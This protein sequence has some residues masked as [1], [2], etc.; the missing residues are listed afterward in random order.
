MPFLNTFEN[1]DYL[2]HGL[3]LDVTIGGIYL[4]EDLFNIDSNQ[5]LKAFV[6]KESFLKLGESQKIFNQD[7]YRRYHSIIGESL[8]T[9]FSE[10]NYGSLQEKYDHFIMT[11]SMNRVI[12]QRYRGIRN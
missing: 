12:L 10:L 4:T 6:K 11:Q 5:N 3:D 7:V 8:S 9:I 1:E 2:V